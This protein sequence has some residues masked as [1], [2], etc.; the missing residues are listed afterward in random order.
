MTVTITYLHLEALDK[1]DVALPPFAKL[2]NA[3]VL[4]KTI[5]VILKCP[6]KINRTYEQQ[7]TLDTPFHE[8]LVVLSFECPDDA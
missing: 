7:I 3:H 8:S 2:G 1:I 4:V 5:A 6:K